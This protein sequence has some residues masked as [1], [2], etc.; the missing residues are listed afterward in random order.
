[1]GIEKRQVLLETAVGVVN[2]SG[3]TET[4]CMSA[5]E[6]EQ[7][8]I[9]VVS[10]KGH[11]LLDTV[12]NKTTGFL[13]KTDDKLSDSV[14]KLLKDP[15][16]RKKMGNAAEI[17]SKKFI[18]SEIVPK[19][20]SELNGILGDKAASIRFSHRFMLDDA[21]WLKWYCF[22]LK[23]FFHAEKLPSVSRTA[24]QIKRKIR[25]MFHK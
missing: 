20:K 25:M 24:F 18:C 6:M 14:I 8:G 22:R 1:M 15:V 23:K 21:K 17:Y 11:G 5:I 3:K 12:I 13:V 19:W 4:F 7:M 10:Y 16:L 9:P 2:P